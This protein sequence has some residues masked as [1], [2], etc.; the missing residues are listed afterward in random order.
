MKIA[1]RNEINYSKSRIVGELLLAGVCYCPSID[2]SSILRVFLG[3]FAACFSRFSFNIL[4][5][6]RSKVRGKLLK[7]LHMQQEK[8][9]NLNFP[10]KLVYFSLQAH[11]K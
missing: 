2:T 5:Q 1:N 10:P 4:A 9:E 3:I 7:Y 11:S 6:T 8:S